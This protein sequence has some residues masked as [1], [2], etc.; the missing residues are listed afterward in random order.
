M[1]L[2]VHVKRNSF[3]GLYKRNHI[4]RLYFSC[5][6]NSGAMRIPFLSERSEVRLHSYTERSNKS[7]SI[8]LNFAWT[9]PFCPEVWVVQTQNNP[10]LSYCWQK[11]SL[12]TGVQKRT[13]ST[14][15]HVYRLL[16]AISTLG[17][18]LVSITTIWYC[19]QN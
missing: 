5:L 13:I 2:K 16:I 3:N 14:A 6:W 12:H 19:I 8:S 18:F 7:I 17:W 1:C 4:T 9:S 10:Y 11:P 15:I